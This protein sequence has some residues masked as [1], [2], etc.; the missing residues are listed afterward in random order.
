MKTDNLILALAQDTKPVRSW[1]G[2]FAL[3]AALAVGAAAAMALVA[4]FLGDPL[5]GTHSVGV[6]TFGVKMAFTTSLLLLSGY[7]LYEAAR[8]GHEPRKSVPWLTA[9]F[10]L[11]AI[12]AA[13]ALSGAPS[14]ATRALIFGSSW[15]T[16]LLSVTPPLRA[17]LRRAP[18]R[19]SPACADG[20]EAYWIAG[21]A[22]LG[23]FRRA[24][25]CTALPGIEP[26][27]PARLVWLGYR[28]SGPRRPRCWPAPAALVRA[29]W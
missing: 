7:L 18:G 20:L 12:L 8:P 4:I 9:P 19:A 21:R 2:A 3:I 29:T 26:C 10:V 28:R 27:V 13:I 22:G 16:C 11:V 14:G 6:M 23:E 24:R 25:V 5:S 17:G 15:Q 1:Q